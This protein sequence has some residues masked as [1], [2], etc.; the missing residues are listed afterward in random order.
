MKFQPGESGNPAG[1][2]V[3][4]RNKKTIAVDEMLA[5]QTEA[6]VQKILKKAEDGDP[7]AMRLCMERMSPT[8]ANRRL[9]LELPRIN[10][11]DDADA[12]VQLV[13]DAFARE[14]ISIREL[15]CMLAAVD[16]LVRLGDHVEQMRFNEKFRR[17]AD[18][19]DWETFNHEPP[20]HDTPAALAREAAAAARPCCCHAA[21]GHSIPST[22]AAET[23]NYRAAGPARSG[24]RLHSPVN[25][26][27]ADSTPPAR[28][29][30]GNGL[31]SPVNSSAHAGEEPAR[32]AVDA[33]PP[34]P[35]SDRKPEEG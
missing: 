9:G 17:E 16:R 12:A 26:A 27:G 18:Q 30:N 19:R 5:E 11:V 6:A 29:G 13:L 23:G 4:S 21:N 32:E 14:E 10:G 2:P 25:P 20:Y 22:A 7:T 15:A 3:G 31:Y 24:E 34:S 8:G 1:R 35:A 33:A 28:Q